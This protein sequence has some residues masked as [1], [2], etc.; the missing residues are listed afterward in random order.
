MYRIVFFNDNFVGLNFNG[1]VLEVENLVKLRY[2]KV[3]NMSFMQDSLEGGEVVVK[4][5]GGKRRLDLFNKRWSFNFLLESGSGVGSGRD[6]KFFFIFGSRI[7]KWRVFF[8]D[9]IFYVFILNVV[10]SLLDLDKII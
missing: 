3:E 9:Y 7:S 10:N 2:L 4:R 6:L 1:K 8:G 5:R